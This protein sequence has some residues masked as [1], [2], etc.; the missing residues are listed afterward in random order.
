[1]FDKRAGR[2]TLKERG[3]QLWAYVDRPRAWDAWDIDETYEEIGEEITAIDNIELVEDGPLRVAVRVTRSWRS[4][5]FVQTYRLMSQSSRVDIKTQIDWHERMML[6]RAVFPTTIRTHEAIFETMFGV[7]KRVTHR[8]TTWERARFEVSAHRFV[9][10]SEPTYGVSLL[11]NGKYGHSAVD[12]VLGMSLVR[13]S[14]YPDPTA[15]EGAHE[16]T[17]AFFPHTGDWVDAGVTFEAKA[18]NAP[19]IAVP[20]AED[21]TASAAFVSNEG[22]RLGFGALKKAHDREGLT[23]RVYEPHGIR[24]EASLVFD[25]P[26]KAV[27]R[28]NLLEEDAEGA[29][30]R[31]EGERVTFE[32]RPF[33]IVTMVLEF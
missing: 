17:Y 1:M 16:F 25:R 28:T 4:S 23:L 12:G 27:N 15:D 5:T 7:H 14:L 32:V 33:E 20:V 26:V 29:D 11:N 30:I 6:I 24:G 3:N 9:D 22:V 8:N 19:L 10:L 2:E 18:L 31:V 13:G 21:A